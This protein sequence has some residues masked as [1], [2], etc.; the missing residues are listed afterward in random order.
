MYQPGEVLLIPFPFSDLAASKRRPVLVLTSP[1]SRGDF[2]CLAITSQVQRQQA[3]PLTQDDMQKGT[4]PKA[5]WIRTTKVYTL[6]VD[7]VVSRFGRLTTERFRSAHADFCQH[8][9]CC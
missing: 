9:G 7:L 2:T 3:V 4:L 6:S 5:S 1:D 8:F